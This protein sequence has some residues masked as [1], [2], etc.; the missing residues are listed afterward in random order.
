MKILQ[1]I[2]RFFAAPTAVQIAREKAIIESL[3]V[4][5]QF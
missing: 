2:K 4:I 5:E 1:V 3:D